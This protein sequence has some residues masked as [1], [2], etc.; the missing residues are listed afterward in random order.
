MSDIQQDE[1]VFPSIPLTATFQLTSEALEEAVSTLAGSSSS[2]IDESKISGLGVDLMQDD[3]FT[4]KLDS[5]IS[6][7]EKVK[8]AFSMAE[9]VQNQID[10]VEYKLD[11]MEIDEFDAFVDLRRKVEAIEEDQLDRRLDQLER[12]FGAIFN[13][14]Y[15]SL[16]DPSKV[17]GD[18][19][20]FNLRADSPAVTG[21]IKQFAPDCEDTSEQS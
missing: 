9:E 19:M 10:D 14:I 11:Y 17:D 6:N 5:N 8:E 16:A 18:Y 13:T 3:N 2:G 12:M 4:D 20:A 7:N 21:I 15:T 1:K